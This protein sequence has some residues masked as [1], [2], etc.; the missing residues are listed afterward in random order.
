MLQF[1]MLK[2]RFTPLFSLFALCTLAPLHAQLRTSVPTPERI[3]GYQLGDRFSSHAHIE[4]YILAL[5]DSASDRVRVFPY[6]ESYEGRTL[7]LVVISSPDN[8][9]HLDEIKAGIRK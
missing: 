4:K 9:A 7:Y 6:G 5:R 1:N 2:N 3:L 8:L